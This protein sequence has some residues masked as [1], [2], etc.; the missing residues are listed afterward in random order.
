MEFKQ[1]PIPSNNRPQTSEGNQVIALGV[2]LGVLLLIFYGLM[3][4]NTVRKKSTKENTETSS[5]K[6]QGVSTVAVDHFKKTCSITSVII[7]VLMFL[8]AAAALII[9]AFLL[10]PIH[11]DIVNK[12]QTN[13]TLLY[14]PN[15][16][17]SV[18]NLQDFNMFTFPVACALIILYAILS[19]RSSFKKNLYKGYFAPPVP[20]DYF[21]RIKRKL[22]AVVFAVT[23]ADLLEI[24]YQVL[25]E[26][27]SNGEGV[28]VRYL[29]RIFQV[30]VIGFRYYPILV[31]IHIDTVVALF[32]ATIYSWLDFSVGI[33]N[34]SLCSNYYPTDDLYEETNGSSTD[35]I[36]SL[37]DYYGTGSNL[38]AIDV[39]IDIPR[40]ICLA[41]ISIKLAELFIKKI[42]ARMNLKKKSISTSL[43]LS[44]EEKQLLSY[45]K[46][47]IEARYVRYLFLPV[48]RRPKS[49]T[50]L[51][52]IIPKKIYTIRDDFHYSLRVLSV[53]ASAFMLVFFMTTNFCVKVIPSLATLHQ[54][55]TTIF[56]E[57]FGENKFPLPEFVGPYVASIM[58][59]TVGVLLQLTLQLAAIRRNLF[60]VYHGDI[61]ELPHRATLNTVSLA[62]SNF[63]FLGILSVMLMYMNKLLAQYAFL[64]HWGDV[65]A[66]NNRRWL[67]IFLYFNA[68]L[69]AFLGVVSCVIRIVFTVI[70]AM[71]CMC[72]LDYSPLGR[73]LERFDSGFSAYVGYIYMERE[74]A[75]PVMLCFASYLY[76]NVKLNQTTANRNNENHH[77]T[78]GKISPSPFTSDTRPIIRK[79][80]E[81]NSRILQ[82]WLLALTLIHNPL[83]VYTRKKFLIQKQQQN[84]DV[85]NMY[86]KDR[87]FS[88]R[89]SLISEHDLNQAWLKRI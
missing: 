45:I 83:L 68:F 7:T 63:H 24:V 44:R 35:D 60:Q 41:Y 33:V 54:S 17:C 46:H 65:L 75:H 47:S 56:N 53:Y 82:R 6:V 51:S 89:P 2:L 36:K 12:Y 34:Q 84:A 25:T 27:T 57:L 86:R 38:I 21:A 15:D 52:R 32:L 55:L 40:Y 77:A 20:L 5:I 4:V 80:K 71:V 59:A 1:G 87:V 28:I 43:S 79:T 48:D 78:N 30:L 39:C 19:K 31:A 81:Y 88:I 72:R 42:R 10:K 70:A 14:I 67:M 66:L 76:L 58:F 69:D 85:E 74:H 8:I 62:T 26:N 64:Q 3:I 16:I 37:L 49:K 73:K 61:T 13:Q 29:I 22:A 11:N 18:I 23:A 50:L 9:K